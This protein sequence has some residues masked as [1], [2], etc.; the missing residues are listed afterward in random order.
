MSVTHDFFNCHFVM[1]RYECNQ[2][3]VKCTV[4]KKE[5]EKKKEK[6]YKISIKWVCV[7]L[8]L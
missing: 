1:Q 2:M 7:N 8:F 6:K 3:Y 5:E 4:F